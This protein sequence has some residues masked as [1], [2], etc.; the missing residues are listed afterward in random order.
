MAMFVAAAR[1][2]TS[3]SREPFG[4][5]SA[6]YGIKKVAKRLESDLDGE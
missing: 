1:S 4:A 2:V 3:M 6:V 5:L